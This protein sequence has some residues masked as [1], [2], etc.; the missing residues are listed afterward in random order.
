M[1]YAVIRVRGHSRV[2]FDVEDTMRLMGLTRPNHCVVLPQNDSVLGMLNKS[3]DYITW[4]EVSE[5]MLARMIKFRGRLVGDKPVD[6]AAVKENTKYSSIIALAK[7][8]T[9][10]ETTYAELKEF[11]SVFRLSP[12]KK[13]YEGNKNPYK[14]GGALGYRGKDINALVERML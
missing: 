10:G 1:A 9:K 12:P 7:A 6:D 2:N 4:G 11:K 3:K 5:E 13:G 8:L 14:T